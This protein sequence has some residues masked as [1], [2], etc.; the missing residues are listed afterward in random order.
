[1]EENPRSGS[2]QPKMQNIGANVDRVR[3]L[4]R[5]DRRLDVRLTA[6]LNMGFCS[7]EKL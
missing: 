6:E 4:V 1:V 5:S 7:G 3:T 2:E